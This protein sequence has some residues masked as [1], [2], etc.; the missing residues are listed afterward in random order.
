MKF[1]DLF[2]GL[3]GFHL[4]L[5]ELGHECVFASELDYRLQ[6]LYELNFGLRPVGDIR[7]ISVEDIPEHDIICAGFPC[8]P[9]SKAGVQSGLRDIQR[10]GLFFEIMKIVRHHKPRFLI[11][12]NVPNLPRHNQGATWEVLEAALRNEKYAV[13]YM[14]LSPHEFGIPQNRERVFIVA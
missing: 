12:E 6:D 2:A 9:F 11:L 4:A 7:G 3:G 5:R 13:D 10:G 14:R 8:Q 1:I